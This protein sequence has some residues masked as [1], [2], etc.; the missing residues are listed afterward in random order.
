MENCTAL[1]DK[2]RRG[3]TRE[4]KVDVVHPTA[5]SMIELCRA[6]D[7]EVGDGTTSVDQLAGFH[8][9]YAKTCALVL[10]SME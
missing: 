2:A 4:K 1:S 9:K 3:A 6:Q 5:K 10:S 7:E 8:E